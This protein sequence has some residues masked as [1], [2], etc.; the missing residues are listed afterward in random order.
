MVHTRA[1]EDATLNIPVGS[2]SCGRGHGQAPRHN[3]PPLPPLRAPI[4]I[5]HLLAVQNE[6]MVMLLQNEARRGAECP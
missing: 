5:E 3:P 1:T 6:L 2:A 4:S